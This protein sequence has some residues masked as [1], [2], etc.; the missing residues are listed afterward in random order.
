MH[1]RVLG[2]PEVAGIEGISKALDTTAKGT[3]VLSLPATKTT[4]ETVQSAHQLKGMLLE[5]AE[6]P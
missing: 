5:A 6:I 1:L 3:R 4:Q 2:G